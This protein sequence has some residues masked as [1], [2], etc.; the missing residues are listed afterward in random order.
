[1]PPAQTLLLL[2]AWRPFLDPVQ[3]HRHWWFLLIPLALGISVTYKAIRLRTLERYWREVVAMTVQIVL[4][5]LALA[6]GVYLLVELY[7]AVIAAA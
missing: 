3:L 5:M 1:M 2:A 4:A 7:V 6:A